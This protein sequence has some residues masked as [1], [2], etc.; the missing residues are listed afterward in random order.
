MMMMMMMMNM[1]NM[2]NINSKW[3]FSHSYGM[4]ILHVLAFITMV[5]PSRIVLTSRMKRYH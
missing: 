5:D 3:P 2:V 4:T 1:V